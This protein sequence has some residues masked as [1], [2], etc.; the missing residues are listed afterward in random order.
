MHIMLSRSIILI[1]SPAFSFISSL[2]GLG[3]ARPIEDPHLTR[4]PW[5]SADIEIFIIILYIGSSLD[6]NIDLDI[7]GG[8]IQT[9]MGQHTTI[10]EYGSKMQVS[11]W[12]TIGVKVRSVRYFH[13]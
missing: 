13:T 8:I 4:V 12:K 6:R 9:I 11:K 2:T 5:N 3:I 7:H 10:S 1:L